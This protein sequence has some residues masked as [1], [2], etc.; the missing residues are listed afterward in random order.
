MA[1]DDMALSLIV[2]LLLDPPNTL[3]FLPVP[4]ATPIPISF[5]D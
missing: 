1:A 2:P 5:V 4:A 3:D